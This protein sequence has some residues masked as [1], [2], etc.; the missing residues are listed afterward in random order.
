M[1]KGVSYIVAGILS[2]TDME[3]I[4]MEYVSLQEIN[5][6]PQAHYVGVWLIPSAGLTS[7]FASIKQRSSSELGI[8][9]T[10]AILYLKASWSGRY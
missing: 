4:D 2:E 9:H 3:Q 6:M 7:L 8:F 10:F 1:L 5:L